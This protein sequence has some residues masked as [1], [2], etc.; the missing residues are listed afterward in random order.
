MSFEVSVLVPV[1]NVSAYIERCVHSLFRQTF[2]DIEYIFVNDGTPD[3]SIE[4]LYRVMEEYPHRKPDVKVIHL[5]K[6]EG[7]SVARNVAIE[8]ATGKYI[9]FVDSDD[10]IEKNMVELLY[11]ELTKENAD[12]AVCDLISEY[13]T[14]SEYI[15]DTVPENVADY[16]REQI[17][18]DKSQSYL[19]NKL[20]R[21]EF[22]KKEDCK[23]P[24]G[25]SYLEDRYLMVR[26][27][28]Y[29]KKI[30][31]V[32]KGLYHYIRYNQNS[33]TSSRTNLH[34]ENT[35]AFWTETDKFIRENAIDIDKDIINRLKVESKA[36]LFSD[37][38]SLL[39]SRKYAW[40]FR[41]IELKYISTLRTGEKTILFFTHYK[42]Y[43]LAHI[44]RKLL[45]WKNR[46]SH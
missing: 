6:N 4:K 42:L 1:Y 46:N 30:V 45:H 21:Q 29:A 41:D 38:D 18:N 9:L 5:E 19:C 27:Y 7:T 43:R 22:Y 17:I 32:N 3:D 37:T 2:Q 44:T 20:I 11:S 24:A 35:I 10:Y 15:E 39:L 25:I 36:H 33:T 28:Y 23:L 34:F 14:C 26:F 8:H 40:M 13:P 12:I 31:K 16:F